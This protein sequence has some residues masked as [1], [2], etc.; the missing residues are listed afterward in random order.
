MPGP[1]PLTERMTS[2]IVPPVTIESSSPHETAPPLTWSAVAALIR[3]RNQSGTWLLLL[4]SLW[5]LVLANRGR[6][7]PALLAIFVAGAFVM[8]SLGVILND[9]ADRDFDRLVARTATRPLAAGRLSVRQALAV[10]GLLL[11]VATGLVLLLNPLT[12]WLSPVALFLAAVYPLMKRWIHLPQAVLG[13]AFGWGTIMAWAASRGA[14]ELPAWLLFAATVCWA[15]AYDTIYA[16]Q[17]RE[18]DR[19]VGVKSSALWFGNQVP[20]AVALCLAGMLACLALTGLVSGLGYAYYAMLFVAAGIF[21]L[22]LQ[23]L[24]R[25]LT[26]PEAFAMFYQ[27]IYAGSAILVGLWIGVWVA[28]A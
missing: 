24:Q 10:A 25:P 11:L 15:I 9:L 13:V 5:S 27:H 26:Q 6:P 2:A 17:D 22:Q 12:L 8:R 1:A 21:A 16:L 28:A 7:S 4:P 14:V 19:R 3:L 18:D 20:T 23:K